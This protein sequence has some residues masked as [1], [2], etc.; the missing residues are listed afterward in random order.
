MNII[1]KGIKTYE[2]VVDGVVPAEGADATEVNA[3]GHL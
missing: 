1:L 3:Y 2:V